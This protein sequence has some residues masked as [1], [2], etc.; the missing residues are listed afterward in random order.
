MNFQNTDILSNDF[1]RI[2]NE[3]RGSRGKERGAGGKGKGKRKGIR[4]KVTIQKV[5]LYQVPRVPVFNTE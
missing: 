4:E 3:E 1:Q 2:R 5:H